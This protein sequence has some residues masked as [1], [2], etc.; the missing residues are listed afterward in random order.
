MQKS[1]MCSLSVL[2]KVCSTSDII[3]RRRGEGGTGSRGGDNGTETETEYTVIP[4]ED[5]QVGEWMYRFFGTGTENEWFEGEITDIDVEERFFIHVIH[6]SWLWNHYPSNDTPKF[7]PG[8][9]FQTE[10]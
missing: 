10:L 9:K 8:D 5:L 2:D 7:I 4:F 3:L 6:R 1:Y